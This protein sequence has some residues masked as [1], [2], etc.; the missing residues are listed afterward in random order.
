MTRVKRADKNSMFPRDPCIWCDQDPSWCFL[1]R[2]TARSVCTVEIFVTLI[3][4]TDN[5]YVMLK[6]ATRKR[7]REKR[8]V[9]HMVTTLKR[10][11]EWSLI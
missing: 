3:L 1:R 4:C 10:G 11:L 6:S 8:G 7:I 5:R 9:E 2:H